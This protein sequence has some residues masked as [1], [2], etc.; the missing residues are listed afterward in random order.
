MLYYLPRSKVAVF[1][2]A[3]LALVVAN[4]GCVRPINSPASAASSDSYLFCFWNVENLFDDKNDN[5][6]NKADKMYDEWFAQNPDLLQ[7]KL[8]NLSRALVA[9]NDGKGPDILALAEVEC[10]RAAELLRD[11]MNKRLTDD[12]LHYKYL[13]MREVAAGRHIAPAIISRVPINPRKGHDFDRN[14]RIVEAH[15]EVN[16]HEL[17]VIASHWTSRLD[18]SRSGPSA[19]STE[20]GGA[21]GRAKYGKRIYGRFRAI[22]HSNPKADV[23]I[24]GDFNDTPGDVSVTTHLH[25]V[26]DRELVLKSTPPLLFNLMA[27]LDP[28]QFG[29]IYHRKWY[30]FDQ[31]AVSP[32][33]LDNEGWSCD[34]SSVQTVKITDPSD[35]KGRPWRFGNPRDKFRRGC[36]DHFPVTVCLKVQ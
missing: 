8:D 23:L 31:I 11:A 33:M 20:A 25:A 21:D 7:L 15:L 24:C 18:S 3:V 6:P 13:A 4:A 19:K 26:G 30:I 17:V 29:T 10:E 28:N 36:S 22:H 27:G 1:V 16:G 32:G 9:M 5:R 14:L 34:P 35:P 12:A 2:S